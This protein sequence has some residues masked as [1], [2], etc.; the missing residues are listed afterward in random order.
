[1]PALP[2]LPFTAAVLCAAGVTIGCTSADGGAMHRIFAS[3][4][5]APVEQV[6]AQWGPPQSVQ[7]TPA[8]TAYIWIDELPTAHPPGSGPRDAQLE[9]P[10]T[11]ARCQ[12]KLLAGAN[13]KVTGGEWSGNACCVQTLVGQCA[14]LPRKAESG[15]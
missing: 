4:Q 6:Q 7:S 5:G 14:G 15:S 2:R 3:W 9:P 10:A 8:G 13:G 12:R 1:M 11:T